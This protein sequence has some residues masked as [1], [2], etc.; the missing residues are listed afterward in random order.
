MTNVLLLVPRFPANTFW[1]N[2]ATCRVN[3]ARHSAIPLGLLTVAAML[4]PEWTCRLVDRNVGAVAEA[5]FAWADIVMTGGMIVQRPDCLHLIELA[6]SHGRVVVVGGPDVTSEP[7]FYAR[8]DFRIIGEAETIIEDF[9]LAWQSGLRSGTFTAQKFKAD[10]TRTPVPRYDLLRSH[11]YLYFSVQFSRGCPF[12]CE[13]CDIIELYGR[14]PRVK[15]PAQILRE[16]EVLYNTGYRGHVD[17]VDDNFIGNKKAAKALLPQL[18]AWQRERNYPF[19]FSTE[20]SINLADDDELLTL[21]REASFFVVFVGIESPDGDTLVAMRKKQNTRR[22]LAGSVHKIYQ[23]GMFVIAGFIV[24]FDTEKGSVADDL[25]ACIEDAKIPICMVGLL[26]ALANTQLTARLTREGR[27]YPASWQLKLLNEGGG[28]QCTLGLNFE[29]MRPR[30]DVLADYKKVIDHIYTPRAYFRRLKDAGRLLNCYW[31]PK[32]DAGGSG[33]SI[34]G[35]DA[36]QWLALWRLLRTVLRTHPFLAGSYLKALYEC[37]RV[38]PGALQAVG[39]MAAFYL[40]LGPF[41]HVVSAAA[42][43]QIDEFDCGRWQRPFA[44]VG[45]EETATP[46]LASR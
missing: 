21:M 24:G 41:S 46:A 7:D 6:Q 11:D 32:R 2:K 14:V 16:L 28:D 15:T 36:Q 35:L 23:A 13:F 17:F 27:M 26:T 29:T 30:R 42:A 20:A 8:A 39:N 33:W 44:P 19:V 31:P 45:A 25:I 12:T 10:V 1:N 40:H 3:E 18:I 34:A 5:D 38:N 37:A 43:R 4:P 22:S 9:I